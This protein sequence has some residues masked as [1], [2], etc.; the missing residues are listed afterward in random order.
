MAHGW[1]REEGMSL[2]RTLRGL[3]ASVLCLTLCAA[4]GRASEV[5]AAS[6]SSGIRIHS[7]AETLSGYCRWVDGVL[8]FTVPGGSSWELVTS[9]D[10]PV[11]ANRG[12][13][14]FHPFDPAQVE[15]AL[16]GVRYPLDRISAEVFVL[17]YP[18]R[19]GLESAAGPGLILLS[20]GVREMSSA[21][22]VAEFTHE[23]GHV[24]QHVVMP[25]SDT[26]SWSRYR[27]MRGIDDA[28]VYT[29]SAMHAD[30]P[31][32]IWA[33]DFRVLFG[34]QLANTAGTIENSELEYPTLV[35]GLTSF[36]ASLASAPAKPGALA[37]LGSGARGAVRLARAGFAPAPLDLF[38]VSGRRLATVAPLADALGST[39]LWDGRDAAGRDVRGAVVFARARDGLG[40]TTRIVRLP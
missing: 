35:V 22:Q 25:D 39:W 18:R 40:G 4:A 17:P 2:A 15:V 32:E 36:M 26:E 14:A 12:D 29:S 27:E 23:L 24:V 33:E 1:R 8:V 19:L 38:D 31:H 6:G 30:R 37:V 9:I 21:Q 11:I 3:A 5:S 7:A 13:G 20:P 28:S 10:D 16:A 34:A